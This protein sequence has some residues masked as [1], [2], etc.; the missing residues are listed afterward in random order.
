MSSFTD[1]GVW[2][3]DQA[4][5]VRAATKILT[6][7]DLIYEL[8]LRCP[9]MILGVGSCV[10]NLTGQGKLKTQ[11][12]IVAGK[13]AREIQDLMNGVGLVVGEYCKEVP[14]E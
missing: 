9:L 1:K 13:N 6:V 3:Q 4:N 7:D 11:Q 10:P 2:T 12:V 8:R 14:R 5:V